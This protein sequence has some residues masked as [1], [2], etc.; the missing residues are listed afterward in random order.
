MGRDSVWWVLISVWAGDM[1]NSRLV[2]AVGLA[3]KTGA[4]PAARR[5]VIAC[6]FPETDN[7]IFG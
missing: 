7:S 6:R 1:M 5:F 2:P 4:C 3:A